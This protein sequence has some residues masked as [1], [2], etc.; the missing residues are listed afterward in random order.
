MGPAQ[1]LQW[2]AFQVRGLKHTQDWKSRPVDSRRVPKDS[3]AI[4]EPVHL[5]EESFFDGLHVPDD[6]RFARGRLAGRDE[7]NG[8]EAIPD[9]FMAGE[10]GR[11][12][13]D[14]R[15]D[16]CERYRNRREEVSGG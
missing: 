9:R 6:A 8:D 13:C 5:Q 10:D 14:C 7:L 4:A 12:Q 11:D 1:L 3:C 15:S 16:A 2:R